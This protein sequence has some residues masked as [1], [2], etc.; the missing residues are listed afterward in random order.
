MNTYI[1]ASSNTSVVVTLS[2]D[3]EEE[4]WALLNGF[5][6][7]EMN[8]FRLDDVEEEDDEDEEDNDDYTTKH[9]EAPYGK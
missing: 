5:I 1:F 9:N 6:A 8:D 2:E 7:P 3:T 4:A